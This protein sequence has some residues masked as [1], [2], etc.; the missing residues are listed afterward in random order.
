LI[1][2]GA[3]GVGEFVAR[4]C[5]ARG[6]KVTSLARGQSKSSGKLDGLQH[7]KGD[8]SDPMSV[9]DAVDQCTDA[10]WDLLIFNAGINSGRYSQTALGLERT[11]AVNVFGHQ[12]LFS[13]L[14]RK[15]LVKPGA[16]IVFTTGDIYALAND[17]TANYKYR[18]GPM[19]YARSKLGNLWQ[20][21][22]MTRRY[23][24]LHPIAVHP[25]VVAS[26]F[27]GSKSGPIGWLKNRV[28]ISE[29]VGAQSALIAATQD[30]DP[31]AYWHNV[32]GRVDLAET[33]IANDTEKSGKF[34]EN[35]DTLVQDVLNG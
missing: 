34:W 25:G 31:G 26:G 28:F 17:C 18:A 32:F 21:L 1:T 6:A 11:Y 7:L 13:A 20:A 16:R 15:G 23:P 3:S 33:D 12:L 27:A 30:L 4:G 10:A 19:A 2:G 35:L 9:L 5:I 14:H 24:N 8:L 29:E 22:E